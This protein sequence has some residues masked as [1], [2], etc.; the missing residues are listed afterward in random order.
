ML[1]FL[2]IEQLD[3]HGHWVVWSYGFEREDAEE[4]VTLVNEAF[5]M[6]VCR[7]VVDIH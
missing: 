6:I 7:I 1:P 4:I 5:E 3:R 2:T